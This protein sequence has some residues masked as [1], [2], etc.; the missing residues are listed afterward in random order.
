MGKKKKVYRE[1]NLWQLVY[2]FWLVF[3]LGDFKFIWELLRE[4]S[5]N[6]YSPFIVKPVKHCFWVATYPWSFFFFHFVVS[7]CVMGRGR[8]S[9]GW[10]CSQFTKPVP[11]SVERRRSWSQSLCLFM[12]WG[13][14]KIKAGRMKAP[15]L[16]VSSCFPQRRFFFFSQRWCFL[17]RGF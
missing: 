1:E 11:P 17:S 8:L 4:T 14:G 12:I 7:V 10:G 6:R 3:H 16:P 13:C 2:L 5:Y 9:S 15:K